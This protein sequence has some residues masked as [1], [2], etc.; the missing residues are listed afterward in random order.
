MN[1]VVI[2]LQFFV[3]IFF[4]NLLFSFFIMSLTVTLV[5]MK[6]IPLVAVHRFYSKSRDK[7]YQRAFVM[8]WSLISMSLIIMTILLFNKTLHW[9]SLKE[10]I[11]TGVLVGLISGFISGIALFRSYRMLIERMLK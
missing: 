1:T 3:L 5:L 4:L 10:A 8:I 9:F 6:V 7:S 11:L 2:Y